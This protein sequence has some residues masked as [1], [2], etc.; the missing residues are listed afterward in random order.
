M[1]TASTSRPRRVALF[2][3]CLVDQFFP[4]VGLATPAG[5]CTPPDQNCWQA[6]QQITIPSGV[7]L[8]GASSSVD[9]TGTATPTYDDTTSFEIKFKP[10]GSSDGGTVFLSDREQQKFWRVLVYQYTGS[11]YAREGL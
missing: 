6:L 10:D 4:E 1:S 11:S 5:T 8:Y 7:L 9:V 2:A 3:T